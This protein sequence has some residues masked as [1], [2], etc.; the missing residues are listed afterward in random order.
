MR[1]HLDKEIQEC[2]D[3][4]ALCASKAR[5]VASA[6]AREDFLKLERSWLQLARSYEFTQ[7]LMRDDT[8]DAGPPS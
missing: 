5:N 6:E 8:E 7:Q 1:P 2:R 3:H 4:A